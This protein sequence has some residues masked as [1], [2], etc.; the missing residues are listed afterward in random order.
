MKKNKMK[1]K[2][3]Q[4]KKKPVKNNKLNYFNKNYLKKIII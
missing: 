4:K 1:I 2:K 3:K